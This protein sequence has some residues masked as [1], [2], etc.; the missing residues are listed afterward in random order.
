M[1]LFLTFNG[2]I[3]L[4]Q[5]DWPFHILSIPKWW[6]LLPPSDGSNS[7]HQ[8]M[9]NSKLLL[10]NAV[11]AI[12]STYLLETSWLPS[13]SLSHEPLYEPV[14]VWQLPQSP[15]WWLYVS[16]S[17]GPL[18]DPSDRDWPGDRRQAAVDGRWIFL[19]QLVHP[20]RYTV[21]VHWTPMGLS[22]PSFLYKKTVK[23]LLKI[24]LLLH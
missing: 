21:R 6:L 22:K 19:C 9:A 13:S 10:C 11:M 2:S 5:T 7:T 4:F 18:Y 8:V 1:L 17:D 3:L 12:Q 20:V 23:G 24:C 16:A 14:A 15:Q